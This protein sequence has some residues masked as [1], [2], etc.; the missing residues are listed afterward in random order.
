[1]AFFSDVNCSEHRAL[2]ANPDIA[3]PGVFA[4]FLGTAWLAIGLLLAY[5]FLAFDPAL[6]PLR[7][8]PISDPQPQVPRPN[9]VD[10]SFHRLR[11]SITRV[12]SKRIRS[13]KREEM[14]EKLSIIFSQAVMTMSDLQIISGI[15][16]LISGY[17][18]LPQAMSVYY[19]K[20]IL[21]FAWFST[22]THLA[23]LTCLRTYLF[24]NT[25]KRI[26]RLTL[27][28]FLALILLI[29]MFFTGRINLDPDQYAICYFRLDFDRVPK[30]WSL[31]EDPFLY[32]NPEFEK[33][34]FSEEI[35]MS[36]LLLI[37]NIFVRILKLRR[38]TQNG[39]LAQLSRRLLHWFATGVRRVTPDARR[40]A[41]VGSVF[42]VAYHMLIIQ[43]LVALLTVI[44][45]SA[46]IYLS[47]V[48]EVYALL[49]A[50]IWGTLSLYNKHHSFENNE[51][52]RWEYGQVINVMIFLTPLITLSDQFSNIRMMFLDL[53]S[54]IRGMGCTCH[55][56]LKMWRKE[57]QLTAQ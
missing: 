51:E 3:G 9:P 27:M 38:W 1:M 2:E 26:I 23:A 57:P 25:S 55:V 43:P 8:G 18:T 10:A 39:L 20:F 21:R 45:A 54:E 53:L 17:A 44:N 31:G 47:V 12:V 37:H 11:S 6:D 16:I 14:S 48:S 49:V 41:G 35:L 7:S 52:S 13:P 30:R 42:H 32:I 36:C 5:Y 40:S 15:A 56:I 46:L 4:G 29:A 19:W 28:L 34:G 50:A 33:S 22:I 24:R